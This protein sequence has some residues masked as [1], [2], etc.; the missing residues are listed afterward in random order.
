ME[1]TMADQIQMQAPVRQYLE[2]KMI[3]KEIAGFEIKNV[4]GSG[5]TAVTWS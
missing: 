5:N 2:T 1:V 3:G 4:L